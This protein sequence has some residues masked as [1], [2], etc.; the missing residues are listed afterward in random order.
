MGGGIKNLFSRKK[1]KNQMKQGSDVLF[2]SLSLPPSLPPV[3]FQNSLSFILVVSSSLALATISVDIFHTFPDPA[4]IYLF[5]L[6][7][8][9]IPIQKQNELSPNLVSLGSLF[10]FNCAYSIIFPS[11]LTHLLRLSNSGDWAPIAAHKNPAR[12]L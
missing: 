11:F 1:T 10:L 12:R 5:L 2:H 7:W 6:P 9:D 3:K 8:M 4:S